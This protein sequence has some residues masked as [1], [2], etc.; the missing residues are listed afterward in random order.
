M[1]SRMIATAIAAAWNAKYGETSG[2][3][4]KKLSFWS[5]ATTSSYNVIAALTTKE[6]AGSRPTGQTMTF[7]H[8]AANSAQVSLAT[9]G[10]ITETF[11]DYTIGSDDEEL[12][13]TDNLAQ[14]ADLIISLEETVEGAISGAT[15]ASQIYAFIAK[16]D[17]STVALVE[18]TTSKT[19]ADAASTV[20]SDD[21]FDADAGIYGSIYSGGT[22]DVRKNQTVVEGVVVESGSKRSYVTRIHWLG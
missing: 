14:A 9:T 5:D 10:T 21:I 4:S 15:S 8:I 3:A 2:T 1:A 13:S 18:L 12:A 6:N 7:K 17:G 22:G 20:L 11:V 16:S 19:Q